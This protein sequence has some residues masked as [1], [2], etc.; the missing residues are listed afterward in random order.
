MEEFYANLLRRPQEEGIIPTGPWTAAKRGPQGSQ[1][2]TPVRKKVRYLPPPPSHCKVEL[3]REAQGHENWARDD[4]G[5]MLPAGYAQEE[6]Q[7]TE[8]YWNDNPVFEYEPPE[9]MQMQ[10][11]ELDEEEY[12]WNRNP[13]AGGLKAVQ[14]RTPCQ[15][16]A[17]A[18]KP[19]RARVT[20][21]PKAEMPREPYPPTMKTMDNGDKGHHPCV[22]GGY[23]KP[24]PPRL[25]DQ[26][27][28]RPKAPLRPRPYGNLQSAVMKMP[29]PGLQNLLPSQ[30]SCSLKLCTI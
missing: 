28:E 2:N 25:C 16:Q 17:S 5:S 4:D 23:Q 18:P 14:D 9:R 12:Y 30:G 24:A 27:Q 22:R 3:T 6:Q 11:Q 19:N 26:M 1:R 20:Y 7:G 8:W 10:I 15:P 21:M 13:A 29:S